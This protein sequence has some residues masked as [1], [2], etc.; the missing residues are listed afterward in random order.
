MLCTCV[1]DVAVLEM[2]GGV[3]GTTVQREEVGAGREVRWLGIETW[4][5]GGRLCFTNRGP[6]MQ[7]WSSSVR[8]WTSPR[9]YFPRT[10]ASV[11]PAGG[12]TPKTS[13]CFPSTRVCVEDLHFTSSPETSLVQPALV[14]GTPP[15]HP[16]PLLGGRWEETEVST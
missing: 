14:G 15:S 6:F 4:A 8:L 2:V 7:D 9:G 10:E 5:L 1:V 12:E 16:L 11:P 13:L 3:N